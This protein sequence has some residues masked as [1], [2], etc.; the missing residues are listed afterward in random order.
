M[1]VSL[2]VTFA[3]LVTQGMHS[4]HNMS[5]R[6]LNF[7]N[8]F[9]GGNSDPG[10]YACRI[11]AVNYWFQAYYNL[12]QNAAGNKSFVQPSCEPCPANARC[13]GG[14]CLPVPMMGYWSQGVDRSTTN[15]DGMTS[16]SSQFINEL[17]ESPNWLRIC[18]RSG[19]YLQMHNQGL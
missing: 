15:P 14:L 11:C 5:P 17:T 16:L 12:G 10:M 18:G 6:R 13:G 2:S 4:I 3:P 19:D 1:T 8:V 7:I 9:I